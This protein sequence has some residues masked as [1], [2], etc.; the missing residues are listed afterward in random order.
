MYYCI[1]ATAMTY[2]KSEFLAKKEVYKFIAIDCKKR[3]WEVFSFLFA[4]IQLF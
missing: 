4:Y 3:K 1:I 2:C